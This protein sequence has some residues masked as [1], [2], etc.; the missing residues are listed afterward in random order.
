M[1]FIGSMVAAVTAVVL[2]VLVVML[3]LTLLVAVVDFLGEAGDACVAWGR[4]WGVSGCYNKVGL[5]WDGM[6]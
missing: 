4:G 5:E 1:D 2:V 6:R 3:L